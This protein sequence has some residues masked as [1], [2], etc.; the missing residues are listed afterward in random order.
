MKTPPVHPQ[1][2]PQQLQEGSRLGIDTHADTS[3][4]GAH[5]R[6][7]E[8]INGASYNVSP[9]QGPAIQNV[10][11][12]NGIVAVDKEDGQGGYILQ[13]NSF[14]DFTSSMD[15]SLLCPMQARL[16][17]VRI[18]DVPKKLSPSSTQSMQFEDGAQIPIYFKG[19]I[20]FIHTRYPTDEDM[21]SYEWVQLTPESIWNPHQVDVNVNHLSSYNDEQ[22]VTFSDIGSLCS[23]IEE[24]TLVSSVYVQSK[25]STLTPERLAKLWRIPL[26]LAKLTI[27]AT[28]YTSIRT[29]EGRMSRR[30]RTD[31]YQRRYRRLGGPDS[32]FYTDTL[33]SKVK[34]ISGETCAQLYTNRVGYTAVYPMMAEH[35]A[36]ETLTT[37]VHQVGVPHELHSDGA[38]ALVQG[39]FGK[40][41]RKY[42][43]YTTET[44]PY[45]PWQNH[46]ERENKVI[47][48]MGRYILQATNTP[49]VLWS[50]AFVFVAMIRKLTASSRV[51][52]NGRTPFESIHGYTPDISEYASFEWYQWVWYW[53]PTGAQS[54]R[55]G[56]WCGVTTPI[57]SGHT[58]YILNSK[59]Q[60]ISRS[61]VTH[62][63]DDELHETKEQRNTFD[64]VIQSLIG[65]Y[66]KS[67]VKNHEADP[68]I[69]YKDF[70]INSK[71]DPDDEYEHDLQ[72]NE[73]FT[74]DNEE[75]LP[76]VDSE[77]YHD[78][79]TAEVNDNILG[80]SVLLPVNGELIE[81]IVKSR[82]QTSD[83]KL[84]VG[85]SN[86]NPLLDTRIYNVEFPDGGMEEFTT[87]TIIESLIEHTDE[88]GMNVGYIQGIIDHRRNDNAVKLEDLKDQ[89][90]Q[91]R[92]RVI[93]TKGWDMLVEWEGG[94]TSWIPLKDLKAADPLQT[95]EYAMVNNLDKE[96]AFSWWVKNTLR[97]RDRAI[98]RLKASKASKG[99][100]KFGIRVPSTIA[101]AEELD[102]INGNDYW[103]KAIEKELNKVRVAFEL[104]PDG[105]KVPVGSKLINY[106]II[107]DVKMDLTRKARL[108]AG[109]HMNKNVPKHATY[110]SVVSRESVR[111]VF[112]LA[113]LNGQDIL[114]GDIGNAY[115]NAKPI[116]KCH[117][118]IKDDYLFG[119]S[120]VGKTAIIVRAL[121]G[122]K[123]SGNAWR[124]HLSNILHK[125]LGFQRCLAD[126]DIWY[127]PARNNEELKVYDYVCIYVDDILIASVC[128]SKYM[129]MLGSHVELKEGS[130]KK[131]DSYLGTDIKRFK[132][133]STD[134]EYWALSSNSYLKE[135]L[136]IVQ[137]IMKESGVKVRGKG[138]HPYSI[139]TYRPELDVTPFCD[140]EQLNL[141]Q[142]LIG[143]LCWLIELGRVDIQLESS[144]LSSYLASPRVGHLHQAFH[145]F[146][147][148]RNHDSSWMPMDPRKLDINYV[149][150]Q[151]SSP[152][153][154]R[155]VMKKIYYDA[156]DEVPDNA[157]EAR[158]KSVQLNLYV[159]ADHAGNKVT[160]RSRSGILIF[161][162]MALIVWD[163]KKQNTVES[164]TFGSEYIALKLSM[165]KI[166]GLRYKLR[167]MGVSL[168]GP[169]NVFGDNESVIK[170]TSNPEATLKKKNISIAYHK[171]RECF[172]AG[173]ADMFFIR[174]EENLADLLTKVLP[175]VKR[176]EIFRCIFL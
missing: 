143:I 125:E 97:T 153:A 55:L 166:I 147:Y 110:S 174:S 63:T 113:A 161:M 100:I 33:F 141:Y 139:L 133:D 69:P 13:L 32:R 43:I 80:T 85:K 142:M 65:D 61:S 131:P 91:N 150:P 127:K 9:F 159:D 148:L 116:E 40:K 62:L 89:P 92:R 169:A 136:R 72:V 163:S 126:N 158:G 109:G 137:G 36:H 175:V 59:A 115:L 87:N 75:S 35:Q 172:A 144:Q 56:R 176:K 88:N 26:P 130:V 146:H 168:D 98:S 121:Y 19:P 8:Y 50:Y 11:M 77:E 31:L 119:P 170:S 90:D 155:E 2:S 6:I 151:D 12:I 74:V 17:N 47:K 42:E 135:A 73:V 21:N 111:I 49:I 27:D 132:D 118:V 104:L 96:P 79:I 152:T 41:L 58:Y 102:R 134:Q 84:L 39:E 28:T 86:N 157:P 46:A 78:L 145:I 162:N 95:A 93:T 140:A 99:N 114:T 45:S 15:H 81:G 122:M 156:E 66:N 112:T 124:L 117:V 25:S 105:E 173:I 107:F 160:R 64:N 70:I 53:E 128:P 129:D 76:D 167:M 83:G 24:R 52:M 60:I 138:A 22:Y 71:D 51:G 3:C 30:F 57:G 101:E 44:E 4:A 20:P 68:A 106:H 7:L 171:C 23:N 154:R 29:N 38:K 48:K 108:V 34:S 18:D 82:K 67:K 103:K 37:F 54:Q 149:G 94:T 5:V 16:N 1:L 164:S 10:H 165:E 14:L 120:H 123:S